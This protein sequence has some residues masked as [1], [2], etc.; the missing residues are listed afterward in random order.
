MGSLIFFFVITFFVSCSTTREEQ[1]SDLFKRH[2][3]NFRQCLKG[4][5]AKVLFRIR[6]LP[7]G[8]S[9]ERKIIYKTKVLNDSK[10]C[11]EKALKEMDFSDVVL[12]NP[13]DIFH[14]MIIR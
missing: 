11:V 8:R 10:P 6:L 14:T 1:I 2:R 3:P 4:Q 5:R 9:W 12:E 13:Q 7:D